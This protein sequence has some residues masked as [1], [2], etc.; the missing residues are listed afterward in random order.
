MPARRQSALPLRT[1]P[2]APRRFFTWP[3]LVTSDLTAAFADLEVSVA[4]CVPGGHWHALHS[5]IDI[6]AFEYEYGVNSRRW[7]YNEHHFAE[8]TRTRS[9]SRGEHAGFHDWFVPVCDATGVRGILAAGPVALGRP[10]SADVLERWFRITGLQ[11]HLGDPSFAHYLSATLSTITLEGPQI[12]AF[13]TLLSAF[14]DL[15]AGERPVA[16]IAPEADAARAKLSEVR[17][18]ERM[19]QVARG[20]VDQREVHHWTGRSSLETLQRLSLK[21]VPQHVVVGLVAGEEDVRDP[22]AGVLR[23]NAF[24]RECV[25]LA[26]RVGQMV[27]GRIGEHGVFLLVDDKG[28]RTRTRT[29]LDDLATKMAGAARRFDLRLRCGIGH[30]TDSTSL[31]DC[32]RSALWAAEKALSDGLGVVHGNPKPVR[33]AKQLRELRNQLAESASHSRSISARFDQY[34]EAVLIHC[35]Y[36]LEP[37]RAHLES[38]LERL[39][40]PLLA[41]GALDERS[42]DEMFTRMELSADV[43]ETTTALVTAYRRL[44]SDIEAAIR[45]PRE[46]QQERNLDRALRHVREHLDQPLDLQTVARVAGFAP[47]YFSQLLKHDYGETFEG[48]L[49]H[50]RI[51]RSKHMLDGGLLGIAGISRLCGFRTRNY[52]HRVFKRAVGMTPSQY[53]GRSAETA[54]GRKRRGIT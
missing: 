14:A 49:Q 23:R 34:V 42:F 37:T 51:E 25:A 21:H 1:W 44:V 48:Y 30:G 52:F 18:V 41:T 47:N 15:I 12:A 32:Y 10:S 19:W 29:K 54:G 2:S 24:Q 5:I 40:A 46:T 26:R 11:G 3:A 36:R 28:A 6:Q 4:L 31:S 7:P 13:E 38:G 45:A 50:L 33:R 27:S 9:L 39:G 17:S 22:V 16:S 8:A 53:R 43:A 35:G 20:M